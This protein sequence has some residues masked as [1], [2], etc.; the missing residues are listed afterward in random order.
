MNISE[1]N[2]FKYL[3]LVCP[4]Q[5]FRVWFSWP[6]LQISLI[7]PGQM[8]P[9]ASSPA[10]ALIGLW[11]LKVGR[12][13]LS[14]QAEAGI[15]RGTVPRVPALSPGSTSAWSVLSSPAQPLTMR[16]PAGLHIQAPYTSF[17][18]S[19]CSPPSPWGSC[20]NSAVLS[21]SEHLDQP[22]EQSYTLFLSC[23]LTEMDRLKAPRRQELYLSVPLSLRAKKLIDVQSLWLVVSYRV[24]SPLKFWGFLVCF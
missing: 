20:L 22:L 17:T 13:W 18:A 7:L 21:L 4:P 23:S 15:L 8:P 16:S 1:A 5:P 14:T 12:F 6:P 9:G 19:P 24:C 10:L 3:W 11:N 2:Q